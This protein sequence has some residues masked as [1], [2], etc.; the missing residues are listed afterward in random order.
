MRIH[1]CFEEGERKRGGEKDE[2]KNEK[3]Q[4]NG[5]WPTINQTFN[6]KQKTEK[7]DSAKQIKF[8]SEHT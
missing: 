1:I 8:S 4:R 2:K 7:G 3:M 6:I 5:S